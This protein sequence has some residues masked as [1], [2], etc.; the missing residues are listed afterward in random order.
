MAFNKNSNV[1]TFGFAV[2]LVVI[3]GAGLGVSV[4]FT[5]T[6]SAGEHAPGKNEIYYD[7]DS[8][9]DRRR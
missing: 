2:G 3:V 8:G 4:H 1:F 7:V 6:R 5:Q 9:N